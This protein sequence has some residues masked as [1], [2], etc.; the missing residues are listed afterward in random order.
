LCSA[1]G[2]C[3]R[4]KAAGCAVTIRRGISQVRLTGFTQ[5]GFNNAIATESAFYAAATVTPVI[6]TGVA[7][8]TL[9][10]AFTFAVAT[11]IQTAVKGRSGGRKRCRGNG[12]IGGGIRRREAGTGNARKVVKHRTDRQTNGLTEA[13]TT[14][15]VTTGSGITDGWV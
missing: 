5:S 15:G 2:G 1:A 7:V 13:C 10:A 3:L 8:I 6:V 9:F 14:K 4:D 12:G 11:D